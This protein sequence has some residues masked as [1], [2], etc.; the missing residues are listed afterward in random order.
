MYILGAARQSR[1]NPVHCS[2]SWSSDHCLRKTGKPHAWHCCSHLMPSQSRCHSRL[3]PGL[4][5]TAA[6]EPRAL[7]MTA[8]AASGSA[9]QAAASSFIDVS[10]PAPA[11]SGTP[12]GPIPAL[13]TAPAPPTPPL[14]AS[15]DAVQSGGATTGSIAGLAPAP[16]VSLDIN[17]N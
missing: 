6:S 7:A 16:G 11:G 13:V 12:S 15:L 8:A 4:Q 17:I 1:S 14:A 9:S 3:H 10:P 5:A 2:L